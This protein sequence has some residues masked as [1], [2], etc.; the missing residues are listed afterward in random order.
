MCTKNSGRTNERPQLFLRVSDDLTEQIFDLSLE[1]EFQG[2]EDVKAREQ[3]CGEA[4][5]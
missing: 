2:R 5:V 3:W 1:E 4:M